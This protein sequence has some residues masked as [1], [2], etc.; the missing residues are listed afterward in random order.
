[1]HAKHHHTGLTRG[2]IYPPKSTRFKPPNPPF[3]TE[4]SHFLLAS[5][6]APVSPKLVKKI[7]KLEFVELRELLPDNMA[8]T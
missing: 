4:P 7:Q 6:F 5:S 3:T 8:L 2:G 1:M